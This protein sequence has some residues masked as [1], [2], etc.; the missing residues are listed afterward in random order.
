LDQ[1]LALTLLLF[2][3]V[4]VL[5][6]LLA[7]VAVLGLYISRGRSS[8]LGLSGP[9]HE[10]LPESEC[11]ILFLGTSLTSGHGL[12][13]PD[14]DGYVGVIRARLEELGL[15]CAISNAGEA[16][17]DTRMLLER[18]EL[19]LVAVRPRPGLVVVEI[20]AN[21]MLQGIPARLYPPLMN[22]II[23]TIQKQIPE[24]TILLVGVEPGIGRW[25]RKGGANA[26]QYVYSLRAI[27]RQRGLSLVP[28]IMAGVKY[29]RSMLQDDQTHPNE[30]GARR[31]AENVWPVLV[32]VLRHA[33]F[34]V[35]PN[36]TADI[37]NWAQ[38]PNWHSAGSCLVSDD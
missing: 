12:Q 2:Y 23:D 22:S 21:D 28:D 35:S 4:T 26:I 25:T 10:P 30:R 3:S 11:S 33:G 27:T 5:I 6:A 29:R 7:V 38:P 9:D 32:P 36:S 34:P 16:G 31:M 8:I 24:A 15:H 1:R 18:L 37:P 20:G 17:N 19:V 13:R 14:L